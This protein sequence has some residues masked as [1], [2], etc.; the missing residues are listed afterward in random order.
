MSGV[1]CAVIGTGSWGSLVADQVLAIEGLDLIGVADSSSGRGQAAA[2]RLGCRFYSTSEEVWADPA[3]RAV[4]VAV[5]NH[6]HAPLAR[7]GLGAGKHLLLEKPMALTVEDAALIATEGEQAGLVVMVNHIQRYYAP[8]MAL[9]ELVT[10]GALGTIEAVAVSRRDHLVREKPWLQRRE[11]V[12]GLLY[13]SAC[14]EF[15]LLRWLCGE[16][17][18]ISCLAIDDVIAPEPLDY[19]DL[20]VSQLRF[21]SGALGQIW[22]C[23]SDPLI[24]YDGV[25]TGSTGS[26][27]FDLYDA[28]I[29]WRLLSGEH[30]EQTWDPANRWSPAAWMAGGGIADGESE[31]LSSLLRDFGAAIRQGKATT[32]SAQDGVRATELAQAGYISIVEQRPVALPLAADAQGRKAFLEL[33]TKRRR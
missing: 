33:Q 3:V 28:R 26:A 23:M 8:L 15:D 21:C 24:G 14:H 31:A 9:Q 11:C 6:E 1:G 4:A 30:D 22:N 32:V 5:P 18:S 2:A 27:W 16:V 25:V 7:A 20:I 17:A 29:R 10:S 13:Q 12:G 19:P